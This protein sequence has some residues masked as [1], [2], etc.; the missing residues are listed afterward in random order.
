MRRR[1]LSVALLLVGLV[2]IGGL[3]AASLDPAQEWLKSKHANRETAIA[4]A[5][6]ESRGPLAAHCARCHSE[7]GFLAWLPQLMAGNPGLIVD[8]NTGK[9]AEVPYLTQLGLTKEKVQ[10]I[11]CTVCHGEGFAL[12]VPRQHPHAASGLCGRGRGRWRNVY[13]VPQH[14]QRPHPVGLF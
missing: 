1:I 7:Q 12:R 14:A 10:P 4:V 9:P 3:M 13:D 6:V 2:A 11:T 5:T 8:P